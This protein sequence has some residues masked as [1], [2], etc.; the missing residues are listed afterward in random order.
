MNGILYRI[1]QIN[2]ANVASKKYAIDKNIDCKMWYIKNGVTFFFIN[3]AIIN[4]TKPA[5]PAVKYEPADIS[6]S[7]G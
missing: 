1:T 4:H 3:A 2:S 6:L 7:I 5:P